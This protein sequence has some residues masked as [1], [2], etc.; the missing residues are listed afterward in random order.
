MSPFLVTLAF[1]IVLL[2]SIVLSWVYAP[3]TPT[4]HGFFWSDQRLSLR[5][6]TSLMV[7]GSF[8][9]NGILYQAWLGYITGWW[10]L[11]V[12][13]IW[14]LG[15]IFLALRAPH[16]TEALSKGTLHGIIGS[17]FGPSGSKTA[18][19]ASFAGFGVLIGW[20]AAVGVSVLENLHGITEDISWFAPVVVAVLAGLYTCAGGLK[21]NARVNYVQNVFKG[22]TLVMATVLLVASAKDGLGVLVGS[23]AAHTRLPEAI[24]QLGGIAL[25]SNLLFSFFWQVVDMSNWQDMSSTYGT[26]RRVRSVISSSLVV[27]LFPGVVGSVIGIALSDWGSDLG[28]ITDSNIVSR[29]LEAV[30][31]FPLI[32]VLLVGAYAAS[33]L[34]TIDG[35][36]LSAAQ[37]ITWD[38][39]NRHSVEKVLALGPNREPVQEDSL[40]IAVS[41]LFILLL[42]G[43]G[44]S[45]VIYLVFSL[46]VDLFD[47]VYFAVLAQMSLLG[48]VLYCLYGSRRTQIAK[49]G[50]LPVV[51]S[52][53]LGVLSSLAGKYSGVV[54]L[55]TF[56]PIATIVA[57]ILSAWALPRYVSV[58]GL[59]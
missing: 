12:Q 31:G 10:S 47:V 20:E 53:G 22:A 40:I 6:T 36:A 26:S 48:P 54:D 38:V 43:L 2:V 13:L 9:L 52:L 25:I 27:F 35:A 58:I 50:F 30:A 37:S 5:F 11:T 1:G 16:F 33:M 28:I 15:Y 42:T 56:A 23:P 4:I 3:R 39:T 51:A 34:S 41:R 8:S 32:A 29:F 46:G 24:T 45:V 14:C 17:S 57:S 55:Y 59:A 44:S 49:F 7:S 18:A 19:L 21:G